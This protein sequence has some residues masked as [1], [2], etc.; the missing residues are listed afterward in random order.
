[1]SYQRPLQT[2]LLSTLSRPTR[3]IN[4]LIGPRQVGKTTIARQI[5]QTIGFPTIYA[6]AD[7]PVP[8]DSAWIETHWRRAA[9]EGTTTGMPVLLIFDELQKV[10]GW[11]ET[12]K[13]LWDNRPAAPEIRVLILGSSALMMQEGLTESLAGRFFLHRCTHW[14]FPEC[15]DAFG[16]SLEQWLY[17]GGYP[18]AAEFINDESSWKRYITD[19]LIETVL[20]RDVLQMSK[21]AKPVLLRHL[22]ALAA[23]LPAQCVSY[24][25]MLGQLHDAGNT[26]TL[27]H[28]L[29]LLESAFLASGLELFSHGVQRKRGS[30]PKLVLWNNALVNALSTRSFSD[31]IEDTIW[32]GRLVE[33]AVGAYLCNSLNSVEYSVTYWRDG[34]YEV[35]YVITQG[36]D[37]WAIEVKSG[38]SGKTTGLSRFRARYPDARVLLV[39]AHGIP[40]EEFFTRDIKTWLV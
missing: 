7:S 13:L 2:A 27:A 36:R 18:G 29:K 6:T 28:Y 3:V 37:V 39:G 14:G 5:E 19:S 23:T 21:V 38:R 11:S 15:H 31:S 32:W 30:S 33:N 10:K 9:S 35:D 40:L 17:F 8:L 20:A 16:W 22:F 1:M 25:K 26:T 4:V 34:D 24:T 12:L